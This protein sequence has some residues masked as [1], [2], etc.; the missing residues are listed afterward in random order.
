M[1]LDFAEDQATRR[2]QVFMQDWEVKLDEFLK[3]NDRDVLQG[4]G[5]ISKQEADSHARNEYD[6]F[7]ERSRQYK[8]LAGREES[9]KQLEDTARK[10][11]KNDDKQ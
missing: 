6:Q 3:F 1:W 9:I 11:S 4:A 8:E 10:L 2:R 7:A 5:H